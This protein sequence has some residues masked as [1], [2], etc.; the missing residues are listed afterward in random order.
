M[1]KVLSSLDSL[2]NKKKKS[3]NFFFFF[4]FF[5]D[6]L[7]KKVLK[8]KNPPTLAFHISPCDNNKVENISVPKKKK[9]KKKDASKMCIDFLHSIDIQPR[10]DYSILQFYPILMD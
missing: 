3:F 4:F 5:Y 2:L 10:V 8:E 1:V 9:K 6:L 7:I